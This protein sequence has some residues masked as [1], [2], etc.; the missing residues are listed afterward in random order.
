[1]C[2]AQHTPGT[3]LH[4]DDACSPRPPRSTRAHTSMRCVASCSSRRRSC[5]SR[6][7]RSSS[8]TVRPHVALLSCGGSLALAPPG[9]HTCQDMA[10]TP[11]RHTHTHAHT[12]TRTHNAHNARRCRPR[13]AAA[14]A[15]THSGQP[16]PA[17][18]QAHH[19]HTPGE[20]ATCRVYVGERVCLCVC[21]WRAI[22]HLQPL[23]RVRAHA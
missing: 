20:R 9:Q 10:D 21:A 22:E 6:G 2:A 4:H 15:A 17:G 1:M 5:A 16:A 14:L 8:P 12:H 3:R 18:R 23:L 11:A 19:L 13:A 7:E